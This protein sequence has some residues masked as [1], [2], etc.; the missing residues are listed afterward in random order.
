MPTT[1][2]Q[3]TDR[4][5]RGDRSELRLLGG[6][7]WRRGA[8]DVDLPPAGQRLV[9]LAALRGPISRETASSVLW[10]T[11]ERS[12]AAGNLRSAMWRVGVR[13][14]G[15]L[16][17]EQDHIALSPTT[18]VDARDVVAAARDLARL[19]PGDGL[20]WAAQDRLVRAEELL[21]GWY[22][23]WVLLERERFARL[24]ARSLEA[25]AVA[26]TDR[27]RFG[28][29]IDVGLMAVRCEPLVESAH[30]A[31][32]A[33]HLA[34]GNVAEAR[35]HLAWAARMMSEELGLGP[36]DAILPDGWRH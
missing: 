22:D 9:A 4:S 32:L 11:V 2:G 23:D 24:R 16:T 20:D 30:R 10:P 13:A 28:E 18:S 19:G 29:A 27:G 7:G 8:E 33:T 25:L 1:A 36:T 3:R 5:L 12:R 6:F 21:P 15:L 35:R 31:V 17:T 26:L 14:A 34:A